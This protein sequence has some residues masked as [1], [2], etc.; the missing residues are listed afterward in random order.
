V[1]VFH[2][3]FS[4]VWVRIQVSVPVYANRS[5]CLQPRCCCQLFTATGVC[6]L[7]FL[8]I[9]YAAYTDG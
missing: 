6:Y 8:G 4:P 1:V 9:L 3:L 7:L 2:V 5:G